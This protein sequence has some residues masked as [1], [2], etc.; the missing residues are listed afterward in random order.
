MRPASNKAHNEMNETKGVRIGQ[1]RG[2][3]DSGNDI[4]LFMIIAQQTG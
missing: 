3:L 2:E 4:R 1:S